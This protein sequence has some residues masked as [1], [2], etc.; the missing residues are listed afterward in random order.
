VKTH[1]IHSV[2]DWD[3]FCNWMSDTFNR[4][5]FTPLTLKVGK[6]RKDKTP[7]QHRKYFALL[8]QV[9]KHLKELG[10]QVT[11]D[12]LHECFKARIDYVNTITL[13]NGECIGFTKAIKNSS[14]DVDIKVMNELID[15]VHQWAAE[16]LGLYLE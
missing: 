6:Y 3:E 9:R 8:G 2:K 16:N 15:Y 14:E 7:R 13:D 1:D 4:I 10:H 11:T 12:E 5:G